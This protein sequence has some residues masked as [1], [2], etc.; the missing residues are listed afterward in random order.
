VPDAIRFS[1]AAPVDAMFGAQLIAPFPAVSLDGRRIA[2]L[3]I[4]NGVQLLWI[5]SLDSLNAAALPGTEGAFNPFWSGD[6]RS[7]GF[8]ADGKLKRID[9]M[10][11]AVQTVCD[12]PVSEGGAWSRA[13]VILFGSVTAGLRRDTSGSSP[14]RRRSARRP[15]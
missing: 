8:F 15:P 12:A 2:F 7:I 4:R 1:M 9:A 14:S 6:S 13:G 3:A 10:G 5:R 11:G